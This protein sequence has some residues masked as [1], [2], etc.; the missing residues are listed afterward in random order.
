MDDLKELEVVETIMTDNSLCEHFSKYAKTEF[1]TEN[2]LIYK[3]IE[4]FKKSNDFDKRLIKL[5]N[6]YNNYLNQGFNFFN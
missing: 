1:S 2:I 5:Q 6:I 4:S 3:D